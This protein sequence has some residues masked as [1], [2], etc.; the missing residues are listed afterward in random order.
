MSYNYQTSHKKDREI[1][2][3]SH[4]TQKNEKLRLTQQLDFGSLKKFEPESVQ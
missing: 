1:P 2:K 4:K 3:S